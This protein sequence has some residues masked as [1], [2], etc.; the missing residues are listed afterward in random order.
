MFDLL[1][2]PDSSAHELYRVFDEKRTPAAFVELRDGMITMCGTS[3][4]VVSSQ[5]SIRRSQ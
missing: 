2:N 1:V 4:N 5:G 3:Q